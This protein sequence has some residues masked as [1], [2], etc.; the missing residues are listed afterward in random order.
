MQKKDFWTNESLKDESTKIVQRQFEDAENER[1]PYSISKLIRVA[2][3]NADAAIQFALD[4]ALKTMSLAPIVLAVE[5]AMEHF[6]VSDW[7]D[8]DGF[9]MATF[10]EILRDLNSLQLMID[11]GL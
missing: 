3:I 8:E 2:A 10:G 7:Y 11:D 5:I 1:Y 6:R 4:D 9:G